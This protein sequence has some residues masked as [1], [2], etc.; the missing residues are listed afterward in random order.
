LRLLDGGRAGEVVMRS[1]EKR[2]VKICREK[3]IDQLS[4]GK[5][6]E[7]FRDCMGSL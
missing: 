5:Y 3:C 6:D 7:C 4:S 1:K 2:K